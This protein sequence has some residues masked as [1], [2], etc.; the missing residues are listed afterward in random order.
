MELIMGSA[1]LMAEG[2]AKDL[3]QIKH[4]QHRHH[5]HSHPLLTQSYLQR[6]INTAWPKQVKIT[7]S[8]ILVWQIGY[9]YI[10]RLQLKEEERLV[11]LLEKKHQAFINA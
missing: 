2:F 10:V 9:N 4:G 8:T 5:L 1:K 11:H 3:T 6:Q 7:S